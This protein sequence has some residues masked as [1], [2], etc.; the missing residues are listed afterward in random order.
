M[1]GPAK[2]LAELRLLVLDVDGVLTDGTVVFG[3]G[4]EELKAFHTRD[5]AGLA[6][7]RDAGLLTTFISGRGG[8]AVRR[9]ADELR[10][11]RI[12][13]RARDKAAAFDEMLAHFGVQAGQVVAMGDDVVDLPMLA[14]AGFAAA[15]ADAA[16]DVREMVDL[17]VPSP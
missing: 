17:V 8:A 6:I 11:G 9:R 4:D 16:A 15:P 3:A 13:E 2:P 1:P 14:R 5:G 10:I 12:W 7:W